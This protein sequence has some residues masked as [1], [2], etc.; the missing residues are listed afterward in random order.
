MFLYERTDMINNAETEKAD[1]KVNV[2]ELFQGKFKLK[3]PRLKNILNIF[4]C[5]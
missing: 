2:I 1:W 5:V 3:K 4:L